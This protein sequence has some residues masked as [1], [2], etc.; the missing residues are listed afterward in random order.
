V[1]AWKG[2]RLAALDRRGKVEW[3]LTAARPITNAE[4]SPSGFRIAYREGQDL[5]I[6]AGDGTGDRLLDAGTFRATAWRP[7]A[8]HVLAWNSGAHVDIADVDGGRRLARIRL[9][10]VPGG[11]AWSA[12]GSRLFVNLH[13]WIAV[14]GVHGR[15]TAGFRM[16]G[17]QLIT[18][19]VP[20]RSGNRVA[21]S[22][23]ERVASE[24]ALVGGGHDD[25]LFR[26]D[27]RFTRLQFSPDGRWL[28]AAW[29]LPDQW[30]YLRVGTSGPSRVITSAGVSRRFHVRGFPQLEGWCCPP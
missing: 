27:A 17:H 3:A 12:D 6:V 29:P 1:I 5:R 24:V 15:R 22:R 10:H 19:F 8:A 30:V 25:V 21:V 4:W 20:A 7:G 23:H 9:P 28:L 11:I 2:R 14:Y 16:P 26:G 13:Y 18:T